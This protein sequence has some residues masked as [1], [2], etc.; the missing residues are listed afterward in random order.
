MRLV[1]VPQ[2]AV[3]NAATALQEG[4]D[5]AAKLL[6]EMNETRPGIIAAI[7]RLLGMANVPQT[8]RMA[9]A[10]I[11]NALVF[12]ERIAGVHAEVKPLALVCGDAVT[13]PPRRGAGRVER[14]PGDHLLGLSAR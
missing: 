6:D 1:S 13:N 7:A 12:Q 5:S 11:A 10:I 14:H 8:R 2:R 4:I 3:D 9:C